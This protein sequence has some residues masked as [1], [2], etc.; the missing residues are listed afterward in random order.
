MNMDQV[1]EI[2]DKAR[3]VRPSASAYLETGESSSIHDRD[4][5]G[6]CPWLQMLVLNGETTILCAASNWAISVSI[7]RVVSSRFFIV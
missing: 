1:N 3:S 5:G 6:A 4:D 2:P 7:Q